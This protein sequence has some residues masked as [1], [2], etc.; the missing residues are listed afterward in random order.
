MLGL[1]I[2]SVPELENAPPEVKE[3]ITLFRKIEDFK[4]LEKAVSS[5]K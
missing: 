4:S 3:R 2:Q 5:A 1:P